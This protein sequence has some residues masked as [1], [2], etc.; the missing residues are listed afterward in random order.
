MC[1]SKC[2]LFFTVTFV[3]V[4]VRA[5]LRGLSDEEYND[6]INVIWSYPLLDMKVRAHGM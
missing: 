6:I 2:P 4:V 1:D 5:L 3:F